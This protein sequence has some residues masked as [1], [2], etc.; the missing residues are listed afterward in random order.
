MRTTSR[1]RGALWSAGR[2]HRRDPRHRDV[3]G[4]EHRQLSGARTRSPRSPSTIRAA[5][6][7]SSE[8]KQ[9][10][11]LSRELGIR[12]SSRRDRS[13][14]RWGSP[15]MPGSYR[16]YAVDADGNG[17]PIC[18]TACGHRR[19]RRA[20]SRASR[21]AAWT[22][23]AARGDADAG[24]DTVC[25]TSTAVCPSAGRPR[26]GL[27]TACS[28]RR[29]VRLRR[30]PHWP[31]AAQP[32]E[33]AES[34]SYWIAC[35]NFY[36]LSAITAAILRGRAVLEPRRRQGARAEILRWTDGRGQRSRDPVCGIQPTA[37]RSVTFL[38]EWCRAPRTGQCPTGERY[39][40][41]TAGMLV[42]VHCEA[43]AESWNGAPLPL[44]KA[45][46]R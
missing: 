5:P 41:D 9:F 17:H 20:L 11:L 4:Q 27:P 3:L 44:E 38:G 15:T 26:H 37:A 2:D 32:V 13:R 18:G 36:V 29:V 14:A 23:G 6:P 42:N 34:A 40:T 24:R 22:A 19:Q 7:S 31:V 45:L 10:P 35:S 25:A 1:G 33:G 8:P 21:L 12:R 16:S 28:G 30:R 46:R 39:A 43:R